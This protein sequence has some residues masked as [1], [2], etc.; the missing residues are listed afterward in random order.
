MINGKLART[1]KSATFF[2]IGLHFSKDACKQTKST[3]L[4]LFSPLN[5]LPALQADLEPC[6]SDQVKQ[7]QP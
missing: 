7:L 1:L 4:V 3:R 5:L 6:L 2:K